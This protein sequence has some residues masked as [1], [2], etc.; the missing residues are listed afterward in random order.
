VGHAL[1]NVINPLG[2]LQDHAEDE[3]LHGSTEVDT[4]EV[5]SKSS[6]NVQSFSLG[7]LTGVASNQSV[8]VAVPVEGKFNEFLSSPVLLIESLNHSVARNA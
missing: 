3:G 8:M 4:S 7:V 1:S 2:S 5:S 6:G